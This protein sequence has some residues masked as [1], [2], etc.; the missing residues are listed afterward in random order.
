MAPVTA[1]LAFHAGARGEDVAHDGAD[2]Q[3]RV[4]LG[5]STLEATARLDPGGGVAVHVD[6][7]H[8]VPALLNALFPAMRVQEPVEL[9][10]DLARA[11]TAVD[12]RAEVRAAGARIHAQGSVDVEQRRARSIVVEGRDVDLGAVVAALPRSHL[13]FTLH[14]DGGGPDLERLDGALS[15]AMPPGRLDGAAV[16]PLAV[17]VHA[18]GGRIEIRP[19]ALELPG[20]TIAGGGVS[21]RGRLDGTFQIHA[22]DLALTAR[23]LASAEGGAP[24]P[25]AGRGDVALHVGGSRQAPAIDARG[26]FAALDVAGQSARD[27]VFAV[28]VPD[29]RR[30]EI[31]QA[32]VRSASGG[33]RRAELPR[34]APEPPLAATPDRGRPGDRRRARRWPC[35]CVG[36]GRVIGAPRPSS[37]SRWPAP[38]SSGPSRGWCGS[39]SVR[40]A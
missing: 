37:H 20:L 4:V 22:G 35:R 15:L 2:A 6:R 21:N 13:S 27:L 9:T 7:L 26:R 36:A 40:A 29:L 10:A 39:G 25:V 30:P 31:A 24:L 8:A 19:F 38:G 23:S 33:G 16:G 34:R 17:S 5:D 18:A 32:H 14:A 12:V 11:G 1:P 3:L 28:H